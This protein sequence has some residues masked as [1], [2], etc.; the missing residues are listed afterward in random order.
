MILDPAQALAQLHDYLS[1][2]SN[3]LICQVESESYRI[4]VSLMDQWSIK[5]QVHQG[6]FSA[7]LSELPGKSWISALTRERVYLH[8]YSPYSIEYGQIH[9]LGS[10]FFSEVQQLQQPAND[11]Q[12]LFSGSYSPVSLEWLIRLDL[13]TGIL[14]APNPAGHP[15]WGAMSGDQRA[16]YARYHQIYQD[17]L[18]KLFPIPL[19]LRSFPWIR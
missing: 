6:D 5:Y 14:A 2:L 3:I 19:N 4:L 15:S 12:T 10:L 17:N 13:Q 18:K 1:K 16:L 8:L 7:L 9:P 11:Q